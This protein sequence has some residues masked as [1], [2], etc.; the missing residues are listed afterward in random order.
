MAY[1]HFT[2]PTREIQYTERHTCG[3]LGPLCRRKF[4]IKSSD[5][6]TEVV[7]YFLLWLTNRELLT[8]PTCGYRTYALHYPGGSKKAVAVLQSGVRLRHKSRNNTEKTGQKS[9]VRREVIT[10]HPNTRGDGV[11][12][13]PYSVYE[14]HLTQE[15]GGAF[16]LVKNK[17]DSY[18][19]KQQI[20]N[21]AGTNEPPVAGQIGHRG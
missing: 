15:W 21:S 1:L 18:E 2:R 8:A 14:R 16:L 5:C 13:H 10:S 17:G 11:T 12:T 9:G 6:V 3:S 7:G 20:N 19:T 4:F